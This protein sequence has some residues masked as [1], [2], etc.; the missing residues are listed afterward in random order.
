MS[1][2]TYLI[3][4]HLLFL[5]FTIGYDWVGWKKKSNEE[6]LDLVFTFDHVRTFNKVV[7]HINNHFTKDIQVFKKAKVYF[8]NEEDKFADDRYILNSFSGL[9][10]LYVKHM[11]WNLAKDCNIT[12]HLFQSCGFFLYAWFSNGKCKKC[13]Y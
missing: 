7:I 8:S 13:Q 4:L 2:C 1:N 12:T 9:Y 5:K 10:P 6:T 3:L 11:I